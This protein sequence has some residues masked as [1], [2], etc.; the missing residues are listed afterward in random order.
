MTTK[1]QPL[2]S[3]K[4]TLPPICSILL[5][6]STLT[7]LQYQV[8]FI[9]LN[10]FFAP[11]SS[12]DST[13]AEGRSD[14]KGAVRSAGLFSEDLSTTS[15]LGFRIWRGCCF[16]PFLL[17]EAVLEVPYSEVRMMS[18]I[19]SISIANTSPTRPPA[20]FCRAHWPIRLSAS[21]SR[22]ASQS[23]I[24]EVPM[25][26]AQCYWKHVTLQE[27][28]SNGLA[29][30]FCIAAKECYRLLTRQLYTSEYWLKQ[31]LVDLSRKFNLI[32]EGGIEDG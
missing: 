7:G 26:Q 15:L 22:S 6:R 13:L 17:C 24:R 19:A 3:G 4:K 8:H 29:K 18:K 11:W 16:F 5:H 14:V 21:V 9:F 1:L 10:S 32:F 23:S 27:R 20:A 25:L 30:C 2:R 12:P 28:F 31:I